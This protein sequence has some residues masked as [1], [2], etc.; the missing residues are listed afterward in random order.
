MCASAIGG[1][2]E[3][4]NATL[5]SQLRAICDDYINTIGE[6]AYDPDCEDPGFVFKNFSEYDTHSLYPLQ[7]HR[8]YR[9]YS[10]KLS[11]FIWSK[12]RANLYNKLIVV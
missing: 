1:G 5:I 9:R 3:S 4:Y 7:I 12:N 11:Y 10:S 8:A 2:A 6:H